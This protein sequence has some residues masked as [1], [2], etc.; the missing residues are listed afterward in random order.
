MLV[1][2]LE[3][4]YITSPYGMRLHPISGEYKL[5]NGVDLRA[6]EGT[7]LIAANDGIIKDAS[8][9]I[10]GNGLIIEGSPYT[11]GYCH[12]SS[13]S[14]NAGDYVNAGDLIGY[15]GNTGG[16][17]A[18][19]LHFTVRKNGSLIDPASISYL[20]TQIENDPPPNIYIPPY[21][22][23]DLINSSFNTDI[24][25]PKLNYNKLI[26]IFTSIIVGG[27]LIFLWTREK[28][29]KKPK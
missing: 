11:T 4:F 1:Q 7:P 3:Q 5:H 15:T 10:C 14:V 19:H 8:N 6:S 25:E 16:S 27:G 29:K 22:N 28:N 12:L 18:P 26:L 24:P 17:T 13:I 2:P 21:F 23:P 20:S 9:N